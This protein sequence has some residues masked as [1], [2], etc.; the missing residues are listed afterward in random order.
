MI[1]SNICLHRGSRFVN[2]DEVESVFT[3]TE[4]RTWRP[5]GHIEL[6]TQ[7]EENTRNIGLTISSEKHALSRNG[8]RYFGILEIK[9][10]YV[11]Y[12]WVIGIR[13]SHDKSFPAGVVAGTRVFICDNL[14]FC[15][16]IAVSRKHTVFI[17]EDLPVLVNQAMAGLID[18]WKK[19]DDRINQYKQF[20]LEDA[21]VHDLTIKALDRKAIT[22]RQIPRVL[23]QWRKPA[24]EEFKPRTIWSWFNCVTE[25][26]KGGCAVNC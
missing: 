24:Y 14:A 16:E 8:D 18:H 5:I 25:V 13:N 11:D 15:G 2:R 9:A 26:I 1:N 21:F 22:V 10:S 7:V 12:T 6:L 23:E 3:P 17:M 19:Q 4:T 20:S